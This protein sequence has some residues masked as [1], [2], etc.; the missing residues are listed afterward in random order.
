MIINTQA[1]QVIHITAACAVEHDVGTIIEEARRLPACCTARQSSDGVVTVADRLAVGQSHLYQPTALV[2]T[3]A[4]RP[5]RVAPCRC[6]P[7]CVERRDGRPK[8]SNAV[9][10]I[11]PADTRRWRQ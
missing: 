1:V 10:C 3:V 5:P 2:P 11:C 8:L 9:G 4:C 6:L 7:F